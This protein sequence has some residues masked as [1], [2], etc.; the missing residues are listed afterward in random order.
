MTHAIATVLAVVEDDHDVRLLIRLHLARDPRLEILGEAT[1][2]EEAIALAKSMQ[3]GVVILDHGLNGPMSGLA[4]APLIKAVSPG[5]KIVLFTAYDLAREAA[6]EPAVDAYV[7]K[8]QIRDLL[9]TVD[10]LLG[11]DPLG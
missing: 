6:S 11:L 4:A 2:G 1:S 8:E 3:P 7:R 5:S 9:S 10:R